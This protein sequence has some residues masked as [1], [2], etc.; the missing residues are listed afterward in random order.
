VAEPAK[1]A[2]R[3]A[4]ELEKAGEAAKAAGVRLVIEDEGSCNVGTGHELAA[5]FKMVR[6]TNVGANWDAAN[7]LWHGERPFPDGYDALDKKRIWHMHVKGAQCKGGSENC[8]ETFADQGQVDLAGQ[9][10]A[11][12]R[13]NYKETISLECE[14]VAPGLSHA[15]TTRRSMEG[16]LKVAANGLE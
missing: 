6:A 8:E 1:L 3:I 13:D 11:L 15:A 14:F 2:A 7:G 12:A 9:F 16:L 5:M 4:E 10:R